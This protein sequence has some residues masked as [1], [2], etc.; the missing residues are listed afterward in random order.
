MKL[1]QLALENF[2]FTLVVIFL[3][4]ISGLFAFI[5]MP[6][7]EDPEISSPGMIIFAA[8]PGANAEEIEEEIIQPVD[9][10]LKEITDLGK[11]F[12]TGRDGVASFIIRYAYGTNQ[13]EK[14]AEVVRELNSIRDDLPKDLVEFKMVPIKT[15]QVNIY[16]FALLSETLPYD[17]LN[18]IAED[19]QAKLEVVPGISIAEI[20]GVP[21]EEIVIETDLEKLAVLN[22]PLPRV[23]QAIQTANHSV[24]GG[25]LNIA[26]RKFNVNT[27]SK[28]EHLTDIGK[29]VIQSSEGKIV[30][31]E[32]V[33]TV[34]KQPAQPSHIPRHNGHR[35]I[36]I[37][38]Q[39]KP[40]SN[41]LDIDESVESLF[42]QFKQLLP[43]DVDIV[44]AFNQ[45]T[46][47]RSRIKLFFHSLL[48]GIGLVGLII[49]VMVGFR[50]SMIIMLAIPFSILI[51]LGFVYFMG[52]GMQQMTIAGL[53]VALGLLV[54]N[55]IVV[56]ENI[57]RLIELGYSPR[58]AAIEGAKQ[59]GWPIVSATVTTVFAFIPLAT[60]HDFSG[61]FVRSLPLTV[62]FTIAASLLLALTITP[63]LTSKLF[64]SHTFSSKNIFQRG[65]D[66]FSKGLYKNW[67]QSAIKHP[68]LSMALAGLLLVASLALVPL[69]GSSLF[70]K[71]DKPIF[72]INITAPDGTSIAGTDEIAHEVE[73]VLAQKDYIEFYET[74]VGY[75]NPKIYYNLFPPVR[76]ANFAQILVTVATDNPD[77]LGD[78]VV[79]LRDEFADY[80]RAKISV[81]LFEQGP[82]VEAP[83][84]V[85]ILDRENENL[86]TASEKI[87]EI[88]N[89]IPGII[90]IDNPFSRASIDIEIEIDKDKAGQLG[91]PLTTINQA[92][93]ATVNGLSVSDFFDGKGSKSE[94]VVKTNRDGETTVS[95]LQA[96][97]VQSMSGV[98]ISLDQVAK[99]HLN[100]TLTLVQH[101]NGSNSVSLTSQIA[102]GYNATE[103]TN[104]IRKMIKEEGIDRNVR[105]IIG[106]EI[107]QIE[108]S[109]T[110][111]GKAALIAFIGIFA[112]LVMQFRSFTQP[113]VIFSALPLAVIGS[114]IMLFITG[115]NF[116]FTALIGLT[117]LIGIVVNDSIILVDF[118]NQARQE[119][120][121]KTEALIEA[122][123]V[124]FI[125][126]ILTSLTTIAGLLP[127]TLFAGK[128]WA[129]MGWTIIGGLA[130][131]TVLILV[132]V[133]VLYEIFT[134]E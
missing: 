127:L 15:S 1:P 12:V 129:P 117:S 113:L 134:Q 60:I 24:P 89:N 95:D 109:F 59:V 76:E 108:Q 45:S 82:P 130:T 3:L 58:K 27:N 2:R 50:A 55:A 124:R 118:A 112:V 121:S 72:R 8:Y 66:K 103:L 10:A 119:G 37:T 31:L 128:L 30:Q 23:I 91:I 100:E 52:Y 111:I 90:D 53:V 11:V 46:S 131:S 74:N 41:I 115:N 56:T 88:M 25:S 114:I 47:V 126:I 32:D 63:F 5:T 13:D 19:W 67:L 65:F 35:A 44:M 48:Q 107:E 84:V 33:A 68:W 29:T 79:Q 96:I 93:R 98:I 64:K 6:R 9:D 7:A 70:P 81:R 54:D 133:P 132:I 85:R 104:Q 77:I 14:F 16:Q 97:R 87:E 78:Y 26:N 28:F 43:G 71:A 40:G 20:H 116:S 86:R 125:P 106:G 22:I 123:Q 101:F 21:D 120:K 38:A 49:I 36:F 122:G 83:I 102:P 42:N 62:M 4:V 39:Q 110:G 105:I 61:E 92:V 94:I 99:I 18:R 69:I 51:G 17:A 34:R 75:G 57:A 80:T 73:A